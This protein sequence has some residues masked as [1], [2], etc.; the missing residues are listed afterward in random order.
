VLQQ[1]RSIR[2]S[3]SRPVV[4]SLVTS[5]VL[6]HLDYDVTRHWLVYILR[7]LPSLMNAAAR[8]IYSLSRFDNITPL[9]RQ[10]HWLKAK[11]WIDFKLTVLVFKCV[12]G[13]APPY[14]V[15]ELS[16]PADSQ[17]QC[18]LR[19]ASSLTLVVR[20]THFTTV[21]DCSFTVAASRVWNN[22]P[23]HFIVSPSLRIYKIV[24]RLN[25][26]LIY[27]LNCYI[28]FCKVPAR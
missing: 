19:S 2:R 12:D 8:Q 27:F 23:Q 25:Y 11:E 21:G 28:L 6:N 20:R 9:L 10:L 22:L 26:F 17:A 4:Q 24:L 3:V 1:L 7:W 18:K 5:L 15:D 14:L 16:R 13:S